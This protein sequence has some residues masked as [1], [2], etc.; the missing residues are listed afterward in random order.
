MTH[1]AATRS[2]GAICR[3]WG[4]KPE[5]RRGIQQVRIIT[6]YLMKA[7]LK[8]LL[9]CLISF[10]AIFIIFDLF[11]NLSNFIEAG[12]SIP[13]VLRYYGG[14]VSMYAQWFLP[15]SCLLAALYTMW[16]LSHHSELTAMRASGISF[17]LLLVPFLVASVGMSLLSLWNSEYIAPEASVWS[18]R[19]KESSFTT[20][21]SQEKKN[22][23]FISPSTGR[24]WMFASVD[25]STEYTMAR[26]SG[27]VDVIQ[28]ADGV[29]VSGVHA[30]RAEYLDG[31]WWFHEPRPIEY[32][33]DGQELPQESSK[34]IPDNAPK[35]VP[36]HELVESPRSM[37]LE[38]R[39]AYFKFFLLSDMLLYIKGRK[40]PDKGQWYEFWY[41]IA[42]PWAC[43]VIT[44]FAIPAGIST[45]RKSVM[46][47][48]IMALLAFFSF[49]ALTLA[50]SFL[51]FHGIIP[52]APAALLP[53]L[54]FLVIGVSM[55]RKLT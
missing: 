27:S 55:F 42:S 12:T 39:S 49:Y 23:Q 15:A 7:F 22:V 28:E 17:Y 45:G 30:K 29:K 43:V 16:Q 19:L 3:I 20:A 6:F 34:A 10:N 5:R 46:K 25:P 53:N 41:R 18:E 40:V 37:M 14:V 47:G 11:G 8:P 50:L 36:M 35:R 24:T 33:I 51:A 31:V 38:H 44:I 4:Y 13:V 1:S 26:P 2:A 9:L 32:D 54:V 52:A 21:E 48:V